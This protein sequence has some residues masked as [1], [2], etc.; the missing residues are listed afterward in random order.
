MQIKQAEAVRL[1]LKARAEFVPGASPWGARL[2]EDF[3]TFMRTLNTGLPFI[4]SAANGALDGA[5]KRWS[6]DHQRLGHD[7]TLTQLQVAAQDA[8]HDLGSE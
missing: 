4:F 6:H 5:L 3:R 8:A 7:F 1:L 2:A